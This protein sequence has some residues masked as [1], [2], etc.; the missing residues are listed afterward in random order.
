LALAEAA[1]LLGG[2]LLAGVV[3]AA[4][5]LGGGRDLLGAGGL[6]GAGLLVLAKPPMAGAVE[7]LAEATC[8]AGQ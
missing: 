4:A 3:E 8:G 7:A 5:C 6:L 1:A 2:G